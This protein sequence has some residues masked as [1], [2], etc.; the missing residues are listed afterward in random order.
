MHDSPQ[1]I[2]A[3]DARAAAETAAGEFVESVQAALATHGR[4]AVALS[5]GR[6]PRK[7]HRLLTQSPFKAAFDWERVHLFWVDDRLVP[8]SD[9]ASNFGAAHN[10]LIGPLTLD[11]RLIHPMPVAGDSPA[12]DYE[13]TL[14][15][16]FVPLEDQPPAFDLICLGVGTDGHTASLFPEDPALSEKRRWVAAVEGGTPNV[17]RL[18][19]T[20]PVI[21][22]AKRIMILVT[23]A[24]KADIVRQALEQPG[25]R[26][27]V[28]K[29][30]PTHGSTVWI[31]DASAAQLLS[32][33]DGQPE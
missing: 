21:N 17:S 10:D 13:E 25:A 15:S 26:L 19:L 31:L 20:L 8:Y 27:P 30:R 9:A 22:S 11:R 24:A 1:I 23:G 12:A 33:N 4:A 3:E 5:G 2:I 28:Q 6:T 14:R 29:I 7:L 16:Y 32:G 18:T